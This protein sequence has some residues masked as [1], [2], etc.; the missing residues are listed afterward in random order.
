MWIEHDRNY[1]ESEAIE[2]RISIVEK[3]LIERE[4]SPACSE[5]V[6]VLTGLIGD[7]HG[8]GEEK[9]DPGLEVDGGRGGKMGKADD[10]G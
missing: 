1:R 8:C 10:E 7:H 5:D 6:C 2:E 3:K 4:G 9:G